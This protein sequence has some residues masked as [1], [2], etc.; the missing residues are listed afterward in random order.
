MSSSFKNNKFQILILSLACTLIIFNI[1]KNPNISTY[2]FHKLSI[3]LRN[4]ISVDQIE[5][6][7]QNTPKNFLEKYKKTNYPESQSKEKE[8]DRYQKVLKEMI[9]KKKY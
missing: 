8:L 5:K 7:C 1:Y 9:E 4:L 3:N 2:S 6:R